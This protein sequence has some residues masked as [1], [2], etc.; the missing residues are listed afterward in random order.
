MMG[1]C[2]LPLSKSLSCAFKIGNDGFEQRIP[3]F[4]DNSSIEAFTLNM[5]LGLVTAIYYNIKARISAGLYDS[6]TK[7]QN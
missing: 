5:T 3:V 4:Y 2:W 7:L 1:L 6:L